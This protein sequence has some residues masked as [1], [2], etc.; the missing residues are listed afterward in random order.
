MKS[1]RMKVFQREERRRHPYS[2]STFQ[3][4]ASRRSGQQNRRR[5]RPMWSKGSAGTSILLPPAARCLRGR[6]KMHL[7]AHRAAAERFTGACNP[8]CYGKQRLLPSSYVLSAP[9][10]PQVTHTLSLCLFSAANS[11]KTQ[12]KATAPIPS[13][14]RVPEERVW[15]QPRPRFL[16]KK[17][18]CNR[19]SLSAW[20]VRGAPVPT[21]AASPWE[22]MVTLIL[23]R[24]EGLAHWVGLGV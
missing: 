10:L 21:P 18:L 17:R 7:A 5:T 8:N 3:A 23:A 1:D 14:R 11:S 4:R 24:L 16:V 6:R 19:N 12:T 22:T 13:P 9:T 20:V 15:A 2:R